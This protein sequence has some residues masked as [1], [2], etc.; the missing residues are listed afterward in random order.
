MAPSL[1][2]CIHGEKNERY[3]YRMHSFSC[4]LDPLTSQRKGG[5]SGLPCLPMYSST[6]VFMHWEARPSFCPLGGQTKG[7]V[8]SISFF[9]YSAVQ[10]Q[11]LQ[12]NAPK[13]HGE[14]QRYTGFGAVLLKS[15]PSSFTS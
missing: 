6:H 4:L 1:N 2:R 7:Q 8:D 12:G 14:A 15:R 3:R 10:K 5:W 13:Q 11:I 9:I